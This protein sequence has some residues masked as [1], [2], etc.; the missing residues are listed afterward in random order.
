MKVLP[1][2]IW[3]KTFFEICMYNFWIKSVF[4][5]FSF[6]LRFNSRIWTVQS[7]IHSIASISLAG[8][9]YGVEIVSYMENC[10]EGTP[11]LYL[12]YLL[13]W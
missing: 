4:Q 9:Y 6:L 5:A 10:K 2:W 13:S 11:Y 1:L 7:E 12:S 3:L 8:I